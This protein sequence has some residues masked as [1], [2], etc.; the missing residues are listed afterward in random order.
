MCFVETSQEVTGFAME[1][2]IVSGPEKHV[3]H[4]MIPRLFQL[5]KNKIK[6]RWRKKKIAKKKWFRKKLNILN[7]KNKT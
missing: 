6:T 1:S 3:W 7:A 2:C 4:L 5:K